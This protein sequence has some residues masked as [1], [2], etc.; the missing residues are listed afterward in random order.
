MA[1]N[2]SVVVTGQML[3]KGTRTDE[4]IGVMRK[5]FRPLGTGEG[6]EMNV[7]S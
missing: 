6:R 3:K 7:R 1:L 4:A 2:G 5:E